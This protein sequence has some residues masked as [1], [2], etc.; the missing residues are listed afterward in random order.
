MFVIH[1]RSPTKVILLT[2]EILDVKLTSDFKGRK[3]NYIM[4]LGDVFNKLGNKSDSTLEALSYILP[5]SLNNKLS[6]KPSN[7]SSN[8][9]SKE[10]CPHCHV[11]CVHKDDYWECP[12]CEYTIDDWE[13]EEG[14]GYLS[15]EAVLKDDLDD[16]D[17]NSPIY[18][19]RNQYCPDCHILCIRD[20]SIFNCPT[21]NYSIDDSDIE[22]G[23]GYPTL[24]STYED[25]EDEYPLPDDYE[26]EEDMPEC[27]AACGGPYPQ[28]TTSCK[29]FDD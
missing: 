7:E 9:S 13:S 11:P 18:S 26:P 6:N 1:N 17:E 15:Y 23:S 19:H 12:F 22:D 29:I 3:E 20:G 14:F 5:D 4:K 10:Y 28:C 16:Y 27:C 2:F 25:K 21:C 8:K 24:A